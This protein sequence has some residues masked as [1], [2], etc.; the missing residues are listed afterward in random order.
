M[1]YI[2]T[3]EAYNSTLSSN[4]HEIEV[5]TI[6][7]IQEYINEYKSKK[8]IIDSIYNDFENREDLVN[9]LFSNGFIKDKNE[10]SFNNPLI[11]LQAKYANN[12]RKHKE[13]NLKLE[14][15]N[16]NYNAIDKSSNDESTRVELKSVE[17]II[18]DLKNQIS[19]LNKIITTDQKEVN[20]KLNELIEKTKT[21]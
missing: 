17:D 7:Q 1:K 4:N 16:K 12:V 5:N 19:E 6:E 13:L 11:A 18:K 2:L 15:Y 3:R 20:D 10:L 21:A 8:N 14:E 9:R